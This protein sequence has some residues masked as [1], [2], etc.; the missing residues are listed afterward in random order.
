MKKVSAHFA[1]QA[2]IKNN[3][4]LFIGRHGE[5]SSNLKPVQFICFPV[6]ING[7]GGSVP[8]GSILCQL[9]GNA[10]TNKDQKVTTDVIFRKTLG[11]VLLMREMA[12]SFYSNVI[13][14]SA[15]TGFKLC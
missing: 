2:I 14:F 8:N 15:P 10:V 3:R 4:L 12:F 11:M 6:I 5:Q 9:T 13:F 1:L 7:R